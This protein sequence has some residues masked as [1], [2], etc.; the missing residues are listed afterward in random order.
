MKR[1]VVTGM[2][3][4]SNLG[5]DLQTFWNNLA[6]GRSGIRRITR[7]DTSRH[8]CQI[9]GEVD[10]DAEKEIGDLPNI[11]TDRMAR[12]SQYIVSA[13][14]QA[15]SQSGFPYRTLADQIRAKVTVEIGANLIAMDRI[16][17]EV[18]KVATKGARHALPT[19]VPIVM[20]N[21]PAYW[22]QR[23]FGFHGGGGASGNACATGGKAI[24][25][26][27]EA[28]KTGRALV[29]IAGATEDA[30]E[31]TTIDSFGNSTALCTRY[32]NNPQRGSRPF[33]VDRCGFVPSEGAAVLFLEDYELAKW[34]GAHIL[35]EI[36]GYGITSDADHITSPEESGKWQAWAMED[37]MVMAHILP[38]E[39]DLISAHGTSTLLNDKTESIA[40]WRAYGEP[41]GSIPVIA[42]KSQIGH[43][44]SA[45]MVQESVALIQM[46]NEGVI[47]PTINLD[48]PDPECQLRHAREVTRKDIKVATK[49]G[50]GFGG[51]NVCII[52]RNGK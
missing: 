35:A 42:T 51:G 50:F 7:F 1:V 22:V 18:I 39:I 26:A 27:A 13:T 36:A 32:N 2:G 43:G 16:A 12:A 21:A 10:F 33:D 34:R 20:N 24:I 49:N 41:A 38:E 5:N 4:V 11:R 48:H 25:H 23:V 6:E 47:I 45:A 9:A 28:I 46:M 31:S 40:I 14:K 3:I 37:A 44:M 29:G 8:R 52:Y 17:R 30:I 19:M 15:I